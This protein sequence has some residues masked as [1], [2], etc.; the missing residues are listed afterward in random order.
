MLVLPPVHCPDG[1]GYTPAATR[2]QEL[3]MAINGGHA[4]RSICPAEGSFIA[5]DPAPL[6]TIDH[7]TGFVALDSG[8]IAP[9]I[10]PFPQNLPFTKPYVILPPGIY[11]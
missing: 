4:P 11:F 3:P 1:I 8:H 2:G 10:H 6:P 9:P 7:A 5:H